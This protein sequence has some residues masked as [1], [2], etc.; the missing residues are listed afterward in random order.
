MQHHVNISRFFFGLHCV[1]KKYKHDLAMLICDSALLLLFLKSGYIA[2]YV[3]NEIIIYFE[4]NCLVC[5]VLSELQ[6]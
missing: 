5:T 2:F 6:N 4:V 3:V 1:S